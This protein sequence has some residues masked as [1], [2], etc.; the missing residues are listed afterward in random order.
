MEVY[1]ISQQLRPFDRYM[2]NNSHTLTDAD[3]ESYKWLDDGTWFEW[4]LSMFDP[5]IGQIYHIENQQGARQ[6]FKVT[7][8]K[9]DPTPYGYKNFV[10][11]DWDW[12]L[13]S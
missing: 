3:W 7:E 11:V 8:V 10:R 2:L 1:A 13:R 4:N 12:Y 6:I 9:R 5:I